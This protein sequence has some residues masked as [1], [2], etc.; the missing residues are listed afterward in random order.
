MAVEVPVVTLAA[1]IQRHGIPDFCKLDIEGSE[2]AALA[3]LDRPLP[4][5][6]FEYL[7]A[8]LASTQTCLDR[9][10]ELGPNRFNYSPGETMRPV[11][12]EWAS[13]AEPTLAPGRLPPRPGPSSPRRHTAQTPR[14]A[15]P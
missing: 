8:D 1:L 9:F 7:T 15:R 11:L 14:L 12:P 13:A 3:G 10:G 2:A 6:S 5:L 4:A